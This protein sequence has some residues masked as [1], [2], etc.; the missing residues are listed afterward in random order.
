[1]SQKLLDL[2][3]AGCQLDAEVLEHLWPNIASAQ[4]VGVCALGMTGFTPEK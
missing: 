1:M 2:S 4:A 3:Q